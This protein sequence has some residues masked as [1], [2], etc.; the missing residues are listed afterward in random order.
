MTRNLGEIL[1]KEDFVVNSEYLTTL[2][3][4][5]PKHSID[6]WFVNYETLCEYIVP[7]SSK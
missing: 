5:V 7:R 1:K 6:E 2:V 4:I 3:V